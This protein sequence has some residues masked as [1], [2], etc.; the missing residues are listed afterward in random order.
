MTNS[1]LG[2][3]ITELEEKLNSKIEEY[4]SAIKS[5]KSREQVL[6]KNVQKNS[7]DIAEHV[8]KCKDIHRTFGY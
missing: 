7:E 6:Q 8:H 3:K 2:K 5:L 4:D 1:Q